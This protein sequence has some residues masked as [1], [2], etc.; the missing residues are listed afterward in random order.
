MQK[1]LEGRRI[2]LASTSDTPAADETHRALES[3]GATVHRL[4]DSDS[5]EQWHGGMYAG[6][7]VVGEGAPR[8]SNDRL[9][10][11]AREFLASEKPVAALGSA[12]DALL[13]AGAL[14]GRRIAARGSL[15]AK[16]ADA[17]VEVASETI[18]VDEALL[19]ACE[20]TDAAEFGRR[21]VGE[22]SRR[23]EEAQVD[24]MSDQSFPASDPPASTSAHAGAERGSEPAA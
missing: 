20:G 10:Q 23:L 15:S 16:A 11:L 4:S 12:V 7:V 1:G 2:A 22:F 17:G 21:V 6:L 5:D 9:Q 18:L 19:T 3:A 8:G 14:S 24:E 13:E